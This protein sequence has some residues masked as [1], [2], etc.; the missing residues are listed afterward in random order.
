MISPERQPIF[1]SLIFNINNILYVS[2]TRRTWHRKRKDALPNVYNVKLVCN[3]AKEKNPSVINFLNK[4]HE[5]V[6]QEKCLF[7]C[8]KEP[9]HF[10]IE[11]GT[12]TVSAS[13]N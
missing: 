4:Q 5:K 2:S 13:R 10:M 11:L 3:L 6:K 12:V 7:I 1:S 8:G 9:V